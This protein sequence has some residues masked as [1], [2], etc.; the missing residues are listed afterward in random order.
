[1]SQFLEIINISKSFGE[2]HVLND[3]NLSLQK[4]KFC[5]MI[6]GNGT[7][8]TTLFN[9][10]TGFI[11]PDNG[12]IIYNNNELNKMNSVKINKLGISRTF[13]DLRIINNLTVRENLLL[14]FKNN[15]GETIIKSFLPQIILRKKYSHF[16]EKTNIILENIHLM[17]VANNLANDISIGQKKL[18]TIGCCIA[19]DPELML[20]DE[21]VA[22]IDNKNY[23]RILDL[24]QVLKNDG[25]TII[26]IEHNLEYINI[27]SDIIWFFN[28][29]NISEF[30]DFVLFKDNKTVQEVYLNQC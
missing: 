2:N 11:I 28:K 5:T 21:P 23:R 24:M 10:I 7:G 12:K 8:K 18:L 26:Q 16:Y 14:S 29:S 4:G 13:Q 25:K 3:I 19:N 15:P 1:M 17:D 6:G 20:L 30:Q 22:G 27:L 9:M